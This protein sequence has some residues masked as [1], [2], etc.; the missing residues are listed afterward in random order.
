MCISIT[1]TTMPLQV[2]II[3]SLDIRNGLITD[4]L[5]ATLN[6]STQNFLNTEWNIEHTSL[7]I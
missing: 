6:S 2:T 3:P 5:K 1:I 7:N 4:V